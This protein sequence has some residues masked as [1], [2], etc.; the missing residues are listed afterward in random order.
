[1]KMGSLNKQFL[2]VMFLALSS[3]TVSAHQND[4]K[5][6]NNE[7]QVNAQ[8]EWISSTQELEKA[9][10]AFLKAFS[11]IYKDI[12]LEVL[13]IKNMNDFLNEAFNDEIADMHNSKQKVYYVLAK[14]DN[15]VIGFASFNE[16]EKKGEV[17]IRQLAVDPEFARKGTGSKLVFSIKEQVPHMNRFV[18][19][20]RKV[21]QCAQQFYKKIGFKVSDY[22]HEG[23]S[24]ERYM[25]LELDLDSKQAQA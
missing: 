5:K 16:T 8:L 4:I 9:R 12:P 22:I 2:A 17:Y 18:L 24:P 13:R 19:V 20:T 11:N 15:K 1:M 23:L 3:L 14:V 25:G 6:Q 21:N 10:T 7:L